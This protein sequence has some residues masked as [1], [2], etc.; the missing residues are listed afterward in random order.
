MKLFLLFWYWL[1]KFEADEE[2]IV[3]CVMTDHI[4]K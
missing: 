4:G 2:Y 1:T 3:R